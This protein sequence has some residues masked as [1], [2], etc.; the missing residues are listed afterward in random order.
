MER[1]L[2]DLVRLSA[3]GCNEGIGHEANVLLLRLVSPLSRR[4]NRCWTPWKDVFKLL[5]S[6]TPCQ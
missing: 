2:I 5:E 4:T 1:L 6:C 3:G